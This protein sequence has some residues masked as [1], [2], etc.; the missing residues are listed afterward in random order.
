[1]EEDKNK[2]DSITKVISKAILCTI[3]VSFNLF[4]V[5]LYY[6]N[7]Y[8]GPSSIDKPIIYIY[9]SEEQEV[10]VT[11]LDKDLITCSYP[12]YKDEWRVLAKPD[13][14]L[15]D[16]V[17]G[18]KLYSLY[19]ESKSKYDFKEE[20]EGF[21]VEKKDIANFLEE[22]LEVLGLNYK[23]KEEFIVYWLPKLEQHDYV[24]I[25]FASSEEIEKNMGLA[26]EPKP[27]TL[28]RVLMTWKGLDKKI[29]VKEQKLNSV[30]RTG[31]TIV[32]WGGTEI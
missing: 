11:L 14:E 19:Y 25:R 21:C 10:N 29:E 27:D 5:E 31:Y 7:I 30:S 4:V 13:G 6:V 32:E 28:I 16:L 1:M 22:K 8:Y 17:T 18:N 23:E 3:I 24:Y 26:I 20:Q 2:N 15:L 9:P 12:K